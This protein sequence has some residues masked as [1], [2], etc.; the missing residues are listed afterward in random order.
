VVVGT[1]FFGHDGIVE[2]KL[3]TGDEAMVRVQAD[4][5][6]NIDDVVAVRVNGT[7]RAFAD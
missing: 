6:P 3:A 2:V 1:K 7:V 5:L 4:H